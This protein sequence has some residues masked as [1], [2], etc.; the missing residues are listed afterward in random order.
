ME[1]GIYWEASKFTGTLPNMQ[2]MN[3][4]PQIGYLL[5]IAASDTAAHEQYISG[6]KLANPYASAFPTLLGTSGDN[7]LVTGSQLPIISFAT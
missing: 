4:C 1:A 6:Y 7:L 2:C 5:G 3:A